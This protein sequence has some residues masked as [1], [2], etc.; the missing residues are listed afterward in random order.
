M[1]LETDHPWKEA[2]EVYFEPFIRLFFMHMHSGIDWGKGFVF[3]DQELHQI[4][5]D[6]GKGLRIVDKLV[7]VFLADGRETW[8]LIHIEIQGYAD[9]DFDYRTYVYNYRLH[10]KYTING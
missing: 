4:F 10:D 7:K 5:P 1:P 2:I 3:L 6:D 9:K 8:L